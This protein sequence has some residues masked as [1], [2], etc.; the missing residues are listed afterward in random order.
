MKRY[1][2]FS[3]D[4]KASRAICYALI[5]AVLMVCWILYTGA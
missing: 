2:R 5:G 4:P 1:L 3:D